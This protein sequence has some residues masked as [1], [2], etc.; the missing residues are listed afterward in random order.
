M[1]EYII[2]VAAAAIVAAF[3]DVLAPKKWSGYIRIVIGFLILS[4][5]LAP[6]AK[7][8]D[9][10]IFSSTPDYDISDA[11]LKDRVSE[12]LRKNVE[13]DI[14]ERILDEFGV[15]AEATVEID[16]DEE[17]NIKGV[18]AIR[19]KT[20]KNPDGLEERLKDVYGCNRI[21]FKFE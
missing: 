12:E 4:V 7:F 8:K 5:L 3:A 1:K 21:E 20:W 13:K 6:V 14:E 16:V 11:P 9:V 15:E 10:E 18:R 17:H 2:T 19:I